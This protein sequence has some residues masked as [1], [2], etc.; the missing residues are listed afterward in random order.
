MEYYLKVKS[1]QERTGDTRKIY[2]IFKVLYLGDLVYLDRFAKQ[3]SRQNLPEQR[4]LNA[5]KILIDRGIIADFNKP[6][7][8]L[9]KNGLKLY[10]LNGE[11]V[12]L[13]KKPSNKSRSVDFAVKLLND[14]FVF[15]SHK[16]GTCRGGTQNNQ[17]DYLE[18]YMEECKNGKSYYIAMGDGAYYTDKIIKIYIIITAIIILWLLIKIIYTKY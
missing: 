10:I 8:V 12:W 7:K 17:H 4:I 14:K 5:G 13:S 11:E 6:E 18:H 15:I 1:F 2:E 3:S 9:N 16:Y